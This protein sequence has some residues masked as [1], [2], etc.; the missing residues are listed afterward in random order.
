MIT[1]LKVNTCEF[2]ERIQRCRTA[3]T[4][5]VA[6][7][8]F[9]LQAGC[10]PQQTQ[11]EMLA[12]RFTV[13]AEK[14][15]DQ[16]YRTM[17]ALQAASEAQVIAVSQ[18]EFDFRSPET[19]AFILNWEAAGV[20]VTQLKID[21]DNMVTSC[22]EMLG[23]LRT[24]AERINDPDIRMRTVE[25]VD[26]RLQEFQSAVNQTDIAIGRIEN[27][28]QLGNDII[29]SLRIVGTANLIQQKI[30]ELESKKEEAMASFP[31]V[32]S[33]IAEGYKFLNIEFGEEIFL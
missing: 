26:E 24:R 16:R 18:V 7:L 29:E 13:T 12:S 20:E 19:L 15:E 5:L 31:D 25:Y 11:Y 21:I 27:A 32:D 9:T 3:G 33:I 17:E 23:G 14:L 30:G 1:P 8:L 4:L 10:G 28:M 2:A 6:F 22:F